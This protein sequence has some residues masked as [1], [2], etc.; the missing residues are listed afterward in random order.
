MPVGR[1][2]CEQVVVLASTTKHTTG[3]NRLMNA[4]K[5]LAILRIR[6]ERQRGYTDLS[7]DR[8]PGREDSVLDARVNLIP[9][10]EDLD[11]GHGRARPPIHR[12]GPTT[13]DGL[14]LA[15]RVTVG[16]ATGVEEL[17]VLD[18]QGDCP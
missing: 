1:T 16:T 17:R 4:V 8:P 2:V 5:E 9:V 12:R 7:G 15:V 18:R 3:P 11:S 13:V 6:L 14:L 10:G